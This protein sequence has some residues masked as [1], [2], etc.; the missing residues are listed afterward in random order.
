MKLALLASSVLALSLLPFTSADAQDRGNR[1]DRGRDAAALHSYAPQHQVERGLPT[2]RN[3]VNRLQSP[4]PDKHRRQD[5]YQPQYPQH[6]NRSHR[7]AYSPPRY[8]NIHVYSQPSHWAY[9]QPIAQTHRYRAPRY[10]RPHGYQ[11][12]HW[13]PGYYLPASYRTSHYVVRY[14]HYR[15]PPPPRGYHYIRV[16]DHVVLAAIASGLITE[17]LFNLFYR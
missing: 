14:D 11:S 9:P 4:R 10:A 1:G 17:V 16:D 5:A 2:T 7:Y 13:Q 12:R 6:S 3:E 8:A 15:L